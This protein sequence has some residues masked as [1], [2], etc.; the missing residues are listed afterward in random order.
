VRILI[1]IPVARQQEAGAAGVVFNHARELEKRGHT[2]DC[3]FLD[4]LLPGQAGSGRFAALLFSLRIAKKIL[5]D[6]QMYDVVNLHAPSGCAYGLWRKF[7]RP[8][9][10]PP[11][12]FTMHGSE[13]WISYV[14]TREYRL[15]RA[16]N[17]GWKNRLWHRVYHQNMY[18]FSIRTA[19]YG[20]VVNRAACVVAQITYGGAPGRVRYLPNGAEE[21]FFAPRDYGA[22][23]TLRL[24]FAGSWIDRKGIYYLTEAFALFCARVPDIT[25]TV[26]G[27]ML[28]EEKITSF[29]APEV[30]DRVRVIPL[31]KR[32]DMPSLYAEHDVFVFPSLAEGMPL[33]L[34][35]AMATG[36]PIVTSDAPGMADIVEDEFSGLLVQPA[37][38][39]QLAAAMER[40]CRSADLRLQLGQ[41][42][43]QTARRYTWPIVTQKLERVLLS[44]AALPGAL[45]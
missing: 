32:A 13:E 2:V 6:R 35:E 45:N 27:C 15:G 4:D 23:Q 1:A 16:E 31:V 40:M 12:V 21:S 37:D 26:A 7:L 25:L 39:N 38:A 24:L 41:A 30:R 29:F 18:D 9:G 19:D 43:Q 17:Y 36:M 34:L 14:M 42:A 20:A 33:T 44:A 3:C 5:K 22:R 8:R 11:Y 28:P 10:A